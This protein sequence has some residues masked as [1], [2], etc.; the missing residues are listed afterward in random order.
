VDA[1]FAAVAGLLVA[2]HMLFVV[3]AA[4]GAALVLKRAWVGWLHLPAAAWAVYIEVSGGICPLTPLENA[5]RTR[6]GLDVY[7]GDFVARYLFP[8]L[9][10]DGLTR[11]L[12]MAIGAAVLAINVVLYGVM[13]GRRTNKKPAS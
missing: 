2:G 13:I 9:Y 11:E 6:A 1:L 12:Q 10:P 5:L 8:V 7:S 4:F 3:F